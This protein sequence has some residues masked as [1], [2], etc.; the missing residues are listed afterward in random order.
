MSVISTLIT[1]TATI[2]ATD[3]L[4]TRLCN[5]QREVIEWE[6]TKVIPVP[7]WR[8]AMSYWGFAE[9]EGQWST[10]NWLRIQASQAGDFCSP[11]AFA[12]AMT[13]DLNEQFRK[14]NTCQK[15]DKGIGIHFSAYEYVESRWI[16]ELFLISNWLDTTYTAIRQTVNISRETHHW[17]SGQDP[18]P[19]DA[20]KDRR[21][22]VWQALQDGKW[23]RYNNGDPHLYNLA[24]MAILEMANQ[25]AFRGILRQPDDIETLRSLTLKPVKIVS[26][27]QRDFCVA[28]TRIV[29]GRIHDLAIT[30]AG[31]Y[32]STSGDA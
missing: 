21:L 30:P 15:V 2:H 17:V 26:E 32:S 29:G 22:K 14:I 18:R 31:S 19:E 9:V 6:K 28:N 16:P 4:I 24:A 25:L 10:L 23:L 20:N 8:G 1:R 12:K 7:A 13:I 27:I 11:E 5:G 3:S